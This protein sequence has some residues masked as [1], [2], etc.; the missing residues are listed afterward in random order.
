MPLL[1]LLAHLFTP[2]ALEGWGGFEIRWY[3]L[4]ITLDISI[5][6]FAILHS[7][8]LILK[9]YLSTSQDV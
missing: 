6:S 9:K 5:I 1:T 4:L 8:Y 2:G 3:Q 7:L